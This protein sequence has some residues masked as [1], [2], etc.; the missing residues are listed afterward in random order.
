MRK[1]SIIIIAILLAICFVSYYLY[2]NVIYKE[3]R[4]IQNEKSEFSITA[5]ELSNDF[6]KNAL[7]AYSR[8]SNKTIDIKGQVTEVSDS[9]LVLDKKVFCKM[10]EKINLDFIH[11]NVTIKGRC[12]GYDD[13]FGVVKFDQCSNQ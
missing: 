2:N 4:N 13:L 8:Y 9:A 1:P 12:I 10:N 6:T 11:K 5:S 3:G 7:N